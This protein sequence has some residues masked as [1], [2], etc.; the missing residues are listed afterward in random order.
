MRQQDVQR[1]LRLL[2]A[3]AADPET[4]AVLVAAGADVTIMAAAHLLNQELDALAAASGGDK[5]A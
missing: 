5:A 3:M 4:F 2:A 1:A